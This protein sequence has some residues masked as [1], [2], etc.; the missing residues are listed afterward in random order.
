MLPAKEQCNGVDDD[1]DGQ[2]DEDLSQACKTDCGDGKQVCSA[3]QWGAC[4]APAP[5]T[6]TCNGQDDD[7]DG[8]I[9]EGCSCK[10]GDTQACGSDK[11]VCTKGKQTCSAA[12]QWGECKGETT[13]ATEVCNDKDDDCDGQTDEELNKGCYTGPANTAGKGA[14][15]EGKQTCAAGKWGKCEGEVVPAAETCSGKDDDCNGKVDDLPELQCGKGPCVAKATACANGKPNVCKPHPGKQETCNGVDDDCNGT[16]DDAAKCPA[17]HACTKGVCKSTAPT[18]Y[19]TGNFQ[20]GGSYKVVGKV[21]VFKVSDGERIDFSSS[22]ST[23]SGPDLFIY[24]VKASNGAV[25]GKNFISLGAL[26]KTAGAQS[27]TLK[28]SSTGYKSIVVWCKKFGVNFG[29]ANLTP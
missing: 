29:Y 18:P 21:S 11:G 12:G 5:A 28:Q 20:S 8:Q 7:C 15:A 4:D 2:K 13:A 19:R 26:K 3:G 27:Y 25:S 1:C 14:C 17:G 9:D 16:V 10:A 6:E 24:L 23:S 22:F